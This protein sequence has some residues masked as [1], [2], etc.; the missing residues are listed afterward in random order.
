MKVG[1]IIFDLGTADDIKRLLRSLRLKFLPKHS[2]QYFVFTNTHSEEKFGSDT[3]IVNGF[4]IINTK[5]KSRPLKYTSIH[6]H[7]RKFREFDY[8][9]YLHP[10]S[11]ISDK[12]VDTDVLYE[13]IGVLHPAYYDSKREVFTYEHNKDSRA[14]VDK[15]SG[16]YYFFST[17]TGGKKDRFLK[18]CHYIHDATDEDMD[19]GIY[20]N[21]GDESY[22]NRYYINNP[23]TILDPSFA[24]CT[25]LKDKFKRKI[26][27]DYD[28]T[29]Y[30]GSL[31]RSDLSD[32]T[33]T[34]P[35]RIDS[36]DRLEN[37]ELIVDYLQHNFKT[38]I[39]IGEE[40]YKP[41]LQHLGEKCQ[42]IHYKPTMDRFYRTRILNKMA[43]AAKTPFI[44][45]YDCDIFFFARHYVDAIRKLRDN[46]VDMIYPF[47]GTNVLLER[48]HYYKEIKQHLNIEKIN[49]TKHKKAIASATGYGCAVFFNKKKYIEGG[50]ENEHFRS[51][52]P[53]DQERYH[54]FLKLGYKIDR[55]YDSNAYHLQHHVGVDSSSKNPF[56]GQNDKEFKD[57]KRMSKEQLRNYVKKWSWVGR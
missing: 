40:D 20:T 12:I 56:Y 41:K 38:N 31:N 44:A 33:F 45:N 23:P 34:I 17:F 27:Y 13:S 49:L 18:M 47:G 36:K 46:T 42:Y 19:S 32:M 51:W 53:E 52:G 7:A 24:Y 37:I 26:V 43:M 55:I 39:I 2:K 11:L 21:L 22:L 48:A 9:Y 6:Y 14:Y 54:R 10:K 50:M 30:E 4:V 57:V 29:I 35:V 25:Q 1:I 28:G 5:D 15:N 3:K 8:L 16:K